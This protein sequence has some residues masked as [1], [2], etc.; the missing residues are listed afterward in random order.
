LLI[1]APSAP[2]LEEAQFFAERLRRLGMRADALVLNRVHPEA[3]TAS[4]REA[5]SASLAARG[6][7]VDAEAIMRAQADEVVRARGEAPQL[8]HA[9]SLFAVDDLWLV[10]VM[11]GDVHGLSDLRRVGRTLAS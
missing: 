4:S 11:A 5:L 6:L 2:A 10:P 7:A 1:A 9:R 8:A 3:V